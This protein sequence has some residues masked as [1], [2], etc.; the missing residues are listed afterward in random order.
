MRLRSGHVNIIIGK[1][2]SFDVDGY[3]WLAHTDS[4]I[5]LAYRLSFVTSSV[6]PSH[7][8]SRWYAVPL[9]CL[10]RQ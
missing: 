3:D 8:S 10:A 2:R 6:S 4:T 7:S 1:L 5:A 9:R